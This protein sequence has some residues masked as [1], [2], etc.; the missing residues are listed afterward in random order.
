MHSC[1]D[2]LYWP[3]AE[4]RGLKSLKTIYIWHCN[5]L[6]GTSPLPLSSS[7]SRDGEL[8]PNL[9]ELTIDHCDGL[10]ELP[11]LPAFLKELYVGWCPKLNSL[12]EGLRH[13]TSLKDV[14][15]VGC[16]SLTSLPVDLGHQT[17]LEILVINSCSKLPSLPERMQ[18]HTALWYLSI[19]QCPLLSSL[20][21]GMQGL[22]ALQRLSITQCPL[23]SSLPEG[24][25][26][27]L[28]GLQYLEIEGCPDLERLCKR[29]GPYWD[30]I[31][32]IPRTEILSE[33]RSNFST[34]LPSISCFRRPSTV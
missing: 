12:T 13:A 9:K 1:D 32:H 4:F 19:G 5:K 7:S 20:P 14:R 17:A 29:G 25:Q 24:L 3:E 30:L 15:I 8:L 2:L 10:L 18:G 31:S 23:L 22:T 34:F 6:V 27:R 28:P 16:P 11:K 26:Q 33:R 21:E